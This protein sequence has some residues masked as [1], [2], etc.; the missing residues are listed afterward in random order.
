MSTNIP[1]V[2][3]RPFLSVFMSQLWTDLADQMFL[4]ALTWAI[5]ATGHGLD[6]GLVLMAWA[7]PRGAFL[8]VGGVLIDRWDRRQLGIMT[9]L[10]LAFLIGGLSIGFAT[11][12]LTLPIWLVVAVVLGLLDGIRLPI[13]TALIPLVVPSEHV[14]TAN[15]WSQVRSWMILI[16]GPALGGVITALFQVTGAFL[17]VAGLYLVSGWFLVS[18]PPLPSSSTKQH[19]LKD[20]TEG[21]HFAWKHPRLRLLLP[22]FA[23][24]HLFILGPIAVGIPLFVNNILHSGASGLGVVSGSYGVGM[25]LGTLSMGKWPRWFSTSMMG[26]FTLFA[27]SDCGIALVGFSTTLWM[28]CAAYFFSGFCLGPAAALYQ[29]LLQTSTPPEYLGRV[30]GIAR[31]TSFGLEPV[32]SLM[33]G[34]LSQTLSAGAILIAAGFLATGTDL[35][36]VWRGRCID[37]QDVNDPAPRFV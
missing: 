29:T 11:H 15:R 9:S 24:V 8:L 4:V 35:F 10:L 37:T 3:Q 5:I 28:M 13:A 20:L 27:L 17:V 26:L 36:G 31:A 14:L 30:S 1:A 16:I 21:W 7:L 22:L 25:T 34:I 6:L 12:Q 18:L 33:T 2:F 23:L 32:S 19:I